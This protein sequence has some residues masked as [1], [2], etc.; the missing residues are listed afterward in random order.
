MMQVADEV[1]VVADSTKFG[2]QSLTHLCPLGDIDHLVVDDG[3]TE[4]WRGKVTAVG[5]D[6]LIAEAVR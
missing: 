4:D 1:I 6:L 3:I 2:R 5:V